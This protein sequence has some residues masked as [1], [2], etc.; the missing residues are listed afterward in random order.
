[1]HHL[2]IVV[3]A[4][5]VWMV[6]VPAAMTLMGRANWWLPVG[7]TIGCPRENEGH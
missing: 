6:L 7:L 2:I 5:I 4:T 3:D 1:M